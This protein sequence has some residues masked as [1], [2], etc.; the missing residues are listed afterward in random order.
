MAEQQESI[1]SQVIET[2]KTD[3]PDKEASVVSDD[4][5][6]QDSQPEAGFELV[7]QQEKLQDEAEEVQKPLDTEETALARQKKKEEEPPPVRKIDLSLTRNIGIMAHIDAGKT[8]LTER[9]L[10]YTGRSHKIGEVHDGK[11][12]M[13]WMKQEQERG[14]TITSAATSCFWRE[15]RITIIDTPGH[16]DF[17]AEVERSL[18]VLDGAVAVFCAVGGV[19]PQ[20]E[21]VWRQS[22]KYKVPKIA[23]V[24]KMDRKGAD[25]FAVVND[26]EKTLGANACAMQIPIGAE[27]K[28]KGV[29]DLITMK[30][31]IYDESLKDKG[32]KV[33]DMP[34]GYKDQYQK[35][36]KSLLE[37]AAGCCPELT[38]QYLQSP[39]AITQDQLKRAIRK[40]VISNDLVPV[41]CGSAFKNKGVQNLLDAVVDYLPS[42]KDLPPVQGQDP[43]ETDR[44]I[45]R[46]TRD[47]EDFCGLAFKIQADKHVGKLVYTRIYSGVL[48]AGTYIFNPIKDKKE[49]VGRIVQMHANQRENLDSAFAGDIVALVGLNSTLTGDTLC[50]KENPI[51]LERIEFSEPVVSISIKTA[52][53]TDQDKLGKALAKLAEEDPTFTAYTDEETSETILSGMGELHLEIIVDRIKEEFKINAEVGQPKVAYKETIQGQVTQEYKHV[54]Q[55]GGRGQ[56]GHVIIELL[57]NEAGKGFEFI[58]SIKGGAIPKNY[59][60]AV[61]KGFKEAMKKGPF[62][63]YKVVD[64]KIN[65]IDGS[66]HEVD[67]SEIAF[68]LAA[69]GCFR[70]AFGKASPVLLEPCMK[71]EVTTPEEY[72]SNI[73]GYICSKRGKI[74]GMDPA[75]N[76]KT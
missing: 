75:G 6:A 22:D 67:S 32:F 7:Q 15:N 54:K 73:V 46:Q 37:K 59:I 48:K 60:P 12:Q 29:I 56:Y 27:E 64:I 36:Y 41:F 4:T 68:K 70:E 35:L 53:R 1:P 63:G 14:I 40:G 23:F 16:V 50:N 19:E 8:T 24:N 3:Y 31:Y 33:E 21:T 28:F 17:T 25:Y 43:E 71:L 38:E 74:L 39:E 9:I 30:S 18:R 65:L 57:P 2:A 52:S 55:T 5:E 47:D 11:A 44:I 34:V 69:M 66:Y 45:S 58:D 76:Q 42:P 61:E 49:R 72:A 10:F 26:I 13:D 51:V 62:A 20:S